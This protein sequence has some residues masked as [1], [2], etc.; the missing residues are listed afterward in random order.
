MT[1]ITKKE[2]LESP[3]ICHDVSVKKNKNPNEMTLF[4]I[5]F[6][7][8]AQNGNKIFFCLKWLRNTEWRKE[9]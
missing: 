4:E 7:P 3:Q 8:F 9:F 6:S 1:R 5:Q 2:S